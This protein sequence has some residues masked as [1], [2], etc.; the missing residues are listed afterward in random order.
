[1]TGLPIIAAGGIAD[2]RGLAAAVALGAEGVALGTRLMM[3]RESPI[4][5]RCKEVSLEKGLDDT[6]Y[7]TRFDGQPCRVMKTPAALK[8][9]RRGFDPFR[10]VVN[11]REV[12]QMLDAPW[13]RMAVGVAISGARNA[14]RMAFLANAFH[15][16]RVATLEGELDRVGVLPIGQDVALV[17]DLPSVAELL[18]RMVREAEEAADRLRK[19]F[20][21]GSNG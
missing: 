10:A 8:A 16:F 12:A 13:F 6:L 17:R 4:H 19:V 3:T 11:S 18:E 20:Q 21:D 15:A 1:M 9:L 7:S 2:G 5:P 14:Y